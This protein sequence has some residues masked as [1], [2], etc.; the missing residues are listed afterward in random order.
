MTKQVM[1]QENVIDFLLFS[2][3]KMTS[4]DIAEWKDEKVAFYCAKRAY[5]DMNRTLR[6]SKTYEE[7]GESNKPGRKKFSECICNNIVREVLDILMMSPMTQKIFDDWHEKIC[8]KIISIASE[9]P[10]SVEEK[11]LDEM[12]KHCGANQVCKKRL[13]YG[14][15]QKWLNMTIKYMW[16]TGKWE[17]EF[18]RIESCLHIPVDNYII[19][20]AKNEYG[21]KDALE[22]IIDDEKKENG[23]KKIDPRSRWNKDQY[24]RFQMALKGR[25]GEQMPLE[26][27]G[28]AWM[29]MASKNQ[30]G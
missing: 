14:Q 13:Y 8:E 6:F 29:E 30:K 24:T 7:N 19:E 17:T 21:G 12:V 27:E 20:A 4:K 18:E 11:I 23:R 22:E 5:A 2:L 16:I 26:W 28:K 10:I 3:L 9:C 15:A 25:L 1:V